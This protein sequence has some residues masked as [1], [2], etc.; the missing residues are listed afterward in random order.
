MKKALFLLTSAAIL[1]FTA[2]AES[3]NVDRAH[4]GVKFTVTHMLISDVDG[5]FK[6][7]SGTV[8]SAKEDF[9][10]LKTQFTIQS[11]SIFTDNSKRDEHLISSDFFDAAKYPTIQFTSSSFKKNSAKKYTLTGKLTML[12]VTK[13]VKWDVKASDIIKDPY[14]NNRAGFKATTTIKR[15]DF[16]LASSTP[17]A[18]VSDEVSITVN[19]EVTKK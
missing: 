14:G 19:L 17:N 5:S 10:D 15:S 18:V 7:F 2:N 16:A 1:S 11:N 8:T 12:G 3:W 6:D 13:D 9:S 4:S